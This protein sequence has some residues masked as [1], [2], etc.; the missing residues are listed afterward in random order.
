MNSY[1]G[2]ENVAITLIN[3]VKERVNSVYVSPDGSITEIVE[4]NGI[5]HYAVE[6]VTVSN[7]R[8]AIGDIQPD[9]IHA[10]DF[11]AGTI[12][13]IASG[14]IPVIN[15]LHN[16]SPWIKKLS[17]KSVVYAL[18]CFKYK[19]I[20]TVSNSVMN[21]FVFGKI[22]RNK[23]V[24]VGNPINLST[25]REKANQQLPIQAAQKAAVDIVF[26]GRLTPQKNIFFLLEILKD[27]KEWKPDLTVS[28][29][30]D[31][32]LRNEFEYKIAEYKLQ[33]NITLYGFQDNPYPYIKSAKV[34]CMP[35]AWEG[36]GLAAVEGLALG[37]PVVAAP[38]GG[39]TSI[40]DDSCGKLC[41]EK[42]DY[43]SE[44]YRLLT[45]DCYYSSKSKGS[46]NRAGYFDNIK[47]YS[48]KIIKIYEDITGGM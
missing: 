36:F 47:E 16:N 40:I 38:V 45:D 21:E 32:E 11:T 35:S 24:V 6:K 1:S 17:I 12:C 15:H 23:T 33:D 42:K 4:Q 3:S 10:H 9:I 2:A 26:V 27:L 39:L 28:I 43:V 44:V 46:V 19:R 8:K 18:T 34:M 37:K 25:I 30:G 14:K 29:V 7:I 13:A 5:K 22:F 20:L 41:S 48:N 31:G